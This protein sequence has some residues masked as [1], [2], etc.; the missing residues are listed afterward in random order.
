MTVPT[1]QLS[2]PRWKTVKL[3]DVAAHF[4]D[5]P[6][7]SNLKS[8]D[9]VDSGVRVIRLQNVGVGQMLHDDRAFI[10]REHYESLPRNHCRPGDVIIG[11]LGDPNL[12]A[13]VV[14]KDL[15]RS[16]N[17]ADCLLLRP[18]SEVADARYLSAVLNSERVVQSA[19]A[20]VRGQTRGRI[21]LGR[22]KNL[23][24]PLP[25][26]PEQRRIAD[27]L[28][29]AD[30][31]RRKR[32]RT[33]E[34][35]DQLQRSIFLDLFGDPVTNPKG[36]VSEELAS[37]C[38]VR[39]GVTK[40]RRLGEREM[41]EL[42]YLRVANV[43]DGYLELGD[44]KTIELP[45]DEVDR[46]LLKSGDLVLTEGGDP[47]KLGR[48]AVWEGQ[49]APCIHQNH[50]F[51]VRL[52]TEDLTPSYLSAQIGSRRGKLYFLRSAKQTTG[53][54][55]INMTQLKAFPALVPPKKLQLEFGT[56]IEKL[57]STRS[58][59]GESLGSLGSL[60][61]SLSQRAFRGEL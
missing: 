50:V 54:A 15:A 8:S 23:K 49:I 17:K 40:G 47:D 2:P 59:L 18:H 30:A 3:S 60:F 4:T 9:Y 11:T 33:L 34:L 37:F 29:R 28:D 52:N 35:L 20:L 21:S 55:S 32:Q 58:S 51:R 24:I 1:T 42:P 27:I 39:S 56:R 48:G 16:L 6:F 57:E 10:T 36:W 12:R 46:Y 19:S 22:I 25:P 41:V 61:A 31:L 7:G 45:V 44:V 14:P 5:G 13:C 53:I 26:L 43:Q 38:D